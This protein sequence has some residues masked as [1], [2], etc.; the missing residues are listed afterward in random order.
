MLED[1]DLSVKIGK[2]AYEEKLKKIQLKLVNIQQEFRHS[3]KSL[4][5]LYE[6][7]DAA[8]KGGSIRRITEKMDP[9]GFQVHPIGAPNDVEIAHPYLWR[10]YVKLPET[11]KICILD[12]SWY[13]RVLVERV[14]GF[15]SKKEW[16]RAYDEIN[17]F[18]K[19]LFDNGCHLVKFWLHI[20]KDEQLKRFRERESNAF[21][22][23]KITDD[24]WRNRE[25]WDDYYK[26]AEEMFEKC[27][28]P[29]A[30][31]H[32]VPSNCKRYSRIRTAE[33]V[34]EALETAVGRK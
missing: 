24:D 8:G 25:K 13:G 4:V 27:S 22:N 1:V 28:I 6:G 20:S 33:I 11:G 3:G 16:M 12:R 29:E 32:I 19:Y 31:W 15:A 18:E 10:F 5:V 7:W 2:S 14:E 30:P 17:C 26:A 34:L 21:K 23:W 9:R